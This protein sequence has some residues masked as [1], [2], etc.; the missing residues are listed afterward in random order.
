M[1]AAVLMVSSAIK[2]MEPAWRRTFQPVRAGS[3]LANDYVASPVSREDHGWFRGAIEWDA[4]RLRI[5]G[6]VRTKL[7]LIDEAIM[8]YLWSLA[9][10]FQGEVWPSARRIAEEVGCAISTVHQAKRRLDSAGWLKWTRRCEPVGDLGVRG[11]QV[12]QIT[13]AYRFL[14]PPEAAKLIAK[15]RARKAAAAPIEGDRDDRARSR[16]E[17]E[18]DAFADSPL[19]RSFDLLGDAIR[20]R[21]E[22]ESRDR[23]E[24]PI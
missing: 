4:K 22:R 15:W 14:V 12:R 24:S 21:Q 6:K 10:R 2:R 17:M 1:T 20:R 19:G 8:D 23:G 7:T 5:R 13:N 18:A 3:R 9:R 16:R 11:P